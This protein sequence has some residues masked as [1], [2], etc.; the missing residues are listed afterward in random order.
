MG[1]GSADTLTGVNLD[2]AVRDVLVVVAVSL[3]VLAF[4]IVLLLA[5]R[6][7]RLRRDYTLLQATDTT[8]TFVEVVARQT[9]EVAG[10]RDDVDRLRGELG[11]T[12][13]DLAE[14]IRHVAVVR[15]DAFG[16]LGGRLSFSTALL[17]DGGDGLVMSSIHGRTETRL[18]VKGVKGGGCETPMSP[19]E[20]QAVAAAWHGTSR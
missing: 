19:E 6:L 12:R 5:V 4:L 17:D 18:Y 2:P 8:E 10:L 3:G 7:R 1:R 13:A 11:R 16:D 9:Q 20:Q 14:A 15:Y